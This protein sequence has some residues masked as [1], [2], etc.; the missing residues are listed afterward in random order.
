MTVHGD[1]GAQIIDPVVLVNE[2]RLAL[3][4]GTGDDPE[5]LICG[6]RNAKLLAQLSEVVRVQDVLL[7]ITNEL[8]LRIIESEVVG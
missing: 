2:I 6:R 1:I 8:S 3:E 4:E 5:W 7:R